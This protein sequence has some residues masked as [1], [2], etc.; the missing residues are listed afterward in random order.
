MNGLDCWIPAQAWSSPETVQR[1]LDAV[2]ASIDLAAD[3][4]RCPVSLVMPGTEV[5]AAV[6]EVIASHAI[7]RGVLLADHGVDAVSSSASQGVGIDPA[8]MLSSGI[9]PV[10]LVHAT[11][12]RLVSVR[13]ADLDEGGHRVPPGAGGTGRLDLA[14]YKIALTLRSW[15]SGVVVDLRQWADPVA[16]MEQARVA[17]N[18]ADASSEAW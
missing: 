13:L 3:L 9:D 4:G 1:A 7:N 18:A 2:V 12:A 6:H 14:G 5:E 10:Q 17:W 11:G 15:V 8:A 16:G